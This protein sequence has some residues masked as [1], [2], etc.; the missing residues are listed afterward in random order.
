MQTIEKDLKYCPECRDEYRAEIDSCAACNVKLISGEQLLAAGQNQNNKKAEVVEISEHD[1]LTLLQAGGI[2]E[3]KKL[4]KDLAALG[5][6]ALLI[7]DGNCGGGCCGPEI[8]L[9]IRRQDAAE[10]HACL[11]EQ[12]QRDTGLQQEHRTTQESVFNP[13]AATV[14]CPACLSKFIPESSLCPDCGLQFL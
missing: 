8:Q 14:Q 7:K 9:H 10:A 4:K 3:M 13:Q 5:I 6:P 1:I 12:H 11:L 2:R